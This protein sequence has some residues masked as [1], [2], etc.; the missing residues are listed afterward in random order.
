[1]QFPRSSTLQLPGPVLCARVF[2]NPHS[3]D[4]WQWIKVG[5][6]SKYIIRGVRILIERQLHKPWTRGFHLLLNP[7]RLFSYV[8]WMRFVD[9]SLRQAYGTDVNIV[10]GIPCIRIPSIVH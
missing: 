1:M 6:W 3:P 5:V 4:A 9:Y 7:E 2:D 8:G 10:W